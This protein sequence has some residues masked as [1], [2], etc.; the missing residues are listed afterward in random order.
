M[1]ESLVVEFDKEK[2]EEFLSSGSASPKTMRQYRKVSYETRSRI[3]SEISPR[4]ARTF[5]YSANG[6]IFN[7]VLKTYRANH[8]TRINFSQETRR[9]NTSLHVHNDGEDQSRHHS[10][11]RTLQF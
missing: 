7:E 3:S 8:A 11:L 5:V 6:A 2:F 4:V 10:P 1:L 9:A